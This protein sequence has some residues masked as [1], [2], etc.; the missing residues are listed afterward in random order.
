MLFD[1][2]KIAIFLANSLLSH[3]NI[4]LPSIKTSPESLFKSL[5]IIERR[6]LFPAP[7]G[8]M[9]EVIFPS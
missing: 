8:P 1:C 3:F 6:V 2:L 7:F 4:S 5:L 9:K